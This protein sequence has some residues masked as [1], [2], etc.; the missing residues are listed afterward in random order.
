MGSVGWFRVVTQ[1]GSRIHDDFADRNRETGFPSGSER[2]GPGCVRSRQN[3]LAV[4]TDN[5]ARQAAPRF[6]RRALPAE[7]PA[8]PLIKPCTPIA[9]DSCRSWQSAHGK[10]LASAPVSGMTRSMTTPG[11]PLLCRN[12]TRINGKPHRDNWRRTGRQHDGCGTVLL[13]FQRR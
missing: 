9:G 7:P 3:P 5:S 10:T 8:T 13:P 4:G 11:N 6:E 12:S 2:R 1:P